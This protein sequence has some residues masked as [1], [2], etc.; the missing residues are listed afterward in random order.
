L[1][2]QLH[3][4]HRTFGFTPYLFLSVSTSIFLSV[5][6]FPFRSQ[7]YNSYNIVRMHRKERGQLYNSYNIVRMYRKERGHP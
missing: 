4:R 1:F 7:L 5:S 2:Y 3:L 6:L